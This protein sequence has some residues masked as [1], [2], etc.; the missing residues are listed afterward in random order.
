M[1]TKK[2]TIALTHEQRGQLEIVARSY[3]HSQRERN[4]AKV[5][6]L[7][8]ANREGG[9]RNDAQIAAEVGC[10]PL[11]VSK[12][13][14]RAAL[15]G[16]VESLRH[17][18]QIHRKPRRLDGAAEAQLVTLAC[19][20]APDGRKRWTMQLLKERL[21]EMHVVERIDEATICRTLKKTRSSRG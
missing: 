10:Q 21:I 16:M 17:K 15:R 13:R 14:E 12:I 19:S 20:Q 2:H 8:D 6:L 4:R 18:E 5:L 1:P 9:S 3:R 7:T 11:T